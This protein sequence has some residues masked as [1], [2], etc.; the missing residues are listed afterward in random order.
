MEVTE[1]PGDHAS[2]A[3]GC[4]EELG[5]KGGLEESRPGGRMREGT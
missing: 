1:Y 5:F 3:A 4:L 2:L